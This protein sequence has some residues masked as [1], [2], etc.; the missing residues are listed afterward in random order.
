MLLIKNA[1]IST[2]DNN[3]TELVDIYCDKGIITDILPSYKDNQSKNM[4]DAKGQLVL[5][6]GIDPHVHFD[7]PGYEEREDFAHGTRAAAK[8]GVTTIIDMPDTSIPTVTTK[9]N[10]Y[11]KLEAIKD[12][13]YVDYALWAGVSKNSMKDTWWHDEMNAL[14]EEGVVGF[15]TY[16]ISGMDTFKD[17]SIIELGQVMQ[18]ANKINALV[19]IHAEDKDTIMERVHELVS[20]NRDSLEDYYYSRSEPAEKNGIATAIYLQNQT[21]C[22]LHIVHL[23]SDEG[24]KIIKRAKDMGLDISVETCPH[25]LEFTHKDF[26]KYGSLIQTAPVVK[27]MADKNALWQGLGN[28]SIDFVATDHANCKIEEKETGSCWTDYNGMGNVEFRL[29]YLFS[30]GCLKKKITL[31]QFV[32]LTSEN[33]AK[34]FGLYPQKGVIKK[35]SDADFVFIDPDKDWKVNGKDMYSKNKW[36]PFEGRTFKGKI[37]KTILRGQLVYDDDASGIVTKKGV[38]KWVKRVR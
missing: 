37:T 7:T 30:E 12:N 15:K 33:A 11:K 32:R 31:A 24:L 9:E 22:R 5:P 13:A 21:K 35:G 19:G 38:G 8:G 25:F 6:G 26:E 17:L 4:F 23:G 10:L 2:G 20:K 16:L 27:E 3:K 29:P 14:W 36:T 34:R 28:G 18:H 1:Q